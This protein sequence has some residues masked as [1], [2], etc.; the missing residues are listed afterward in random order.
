V[1]NPGSGFKAEDFLLYKKQ[2]VDKDTEKITR[3]LNLGFETVSNING[4]PTGWFKWGSPAY[5]IRIDTVVKRSGK[6]SLRVEARDETLLSGFGCPARSIPAVYAGKYI[7]VKAFMR[8]EGVDQPIGLLVRIDGKSRSLQFD[9]MQHRGITGTE[10]WEEY[11]VTLPLPE[12][13]EEIYI[14]AIHSGKGKLWVDD[15]QV[16]I[17]SVDLLSATPKP[18]KIYPADSDTEFDNGSKI[19]IKQ[20]TLQTVENLELLCRI[21]GFLKYYHPAVAAGEYN[22]DAELFRVMPAIINAKNSDERNKLFMRWIDRLGK[23]KPDKTKENDNLEVKMLPDFA[24]MENPDLGKTLSRKLNGV[25]NAKRTAQN[26]YFFFYPDTIP[27]FSYEKPYKNM[28]FYNDHGMRLLALFRYWNMVQY[29]HP[30]RYK[31]EKEWNMA[32]GE[33]IPKFLDG[34]LKNEYK[35]TFLE[36]MNKLDDNLSDYKHLLL[37]M[38]EYENDN[39]APYEII[40]VDNKLVVEGYLDEKLTQ[41]S[42]LKRGDIIVEID[43]KSIEDIKGPFMIT[44]SYF[45]FFGTG[46][47]HTDKNNQKLTTQVIRNGKQQTCEVEFYPATEIKYL[48]TKNISHRFLSSDIGYIRP[49]SINSDSL[50]NIMESFMNTK[51]LVIDMRYY[52]NDHVNVDWFGSWLMPH[53]VDY[54]RYS[55]VDITQPGKFILMPALKIGKANKDY[56]KGKIVILVDEATRFKSELFAMALQVVPGATVIGRFT[57]SVDENWSHIELPGNLQTVIPCVGVY[58]PDGRE[59][60]RVGIAIDVEVKSTIQGIKEGR[61]ELLEKAMEIVNENHLSQK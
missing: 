53:P 17:D 1:F 49:V 19:T 56:Y 36:L 29:F 27:N 40:V 45:V 12:R 54:A 6:Y 47:L 32:L 41:K 51:G 55:Q 43:G 38:D 3:N 15:F 24:W 48:H 5:D 61:D 26:Y 13:A 8:T 34:S 28:R 39:I 18:K 20:Y 23:I 35:Q 7:T 25:K 16:L 4:L 2:S 60:Q 31:I 44:P 50:R 9:N 42:G 21:W 14:G 33:F 22:W 30:Y 10:N 59:T 58:H 37:M 52:I 46:L 57:A 11:S